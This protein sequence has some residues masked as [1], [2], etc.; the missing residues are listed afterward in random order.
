[1]NDTVVYS[2]DIDSSWK[3]GQNTDSRLSLETLLS[4][5]P[6]ISTLIST[7]SVGDLISLSRVSS[8]YRALTH[9]FEIPGHT[10]SR[11]T[12]NLNIGQHQTAR[13][14]QLKQAAAFIC[15]SPNHT[16]G[17][18]VHGCKLCSTTIC[19]TCIVR[20]SI[21]NTGENTF[22]KRTRYL[23]EPCWANGN[24]RQDYRFSADESTRELVLHGRPYNQRGI[25]C[26][27]SLKRDAWLCIPC[28][29]RQNLS[30]ASNESP[31]SERYHHPAHRNNTITT[32][33]IPSPI[34]CYGN[35]C[36]NI[37]RLESHGKRRICLWCSKGLAR[38]V[39]GDERHQWEAKNI[40]IRKAEAESR[41]ADIAEWR[42]NRF[43]SLTMSRR[44]MRGSEAYSRLAH[45]EGVGNADSVDDDHP[46][47][48]RHLDA[49]NYELYCLSSQHP[50]TPNDIWRSKHTSYFRY[51]IDFLLHIGAKGTLS[52]AD[53]FPLCLPLSERRQKRTLHNAADF[54]LPASVLEHLHH[55]TQ[56]Q[57]PHA[58]RKSPHQARLNKNLTLQLRYL[59]RPWDTPGRFYMRQLI[60]A[61][62][63]LCTANLIQP[64]ELNKLKRKLKDTAGL[65]VY[66]DILFEQLRDWEET[67]DEEG[68][69]KPNLPMSALNLAMGHI[70]ERGSSTTPS[71]WSDA[72]GD[73]TDGADQEITT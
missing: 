26:G 11:S 43:R 17:D 1:M 3:Y 18:N 70:A 38:Q 42:R 54:Q 64:S 71:L 27:C 10:S 63:R 50:P 4:I 32:D 25:Y 13:W 61:V 49:V 56:I 5:W 7:L 67:E 22:Q 15:A 6:I 21:R 68:S 72:D 23:C 8:T 16:R 51:S 31:S 65:K 62:P 24:L 57:L 36:S 60:L 12:L 47:L 14:R 35:D 73:S 58:R 33:K 52:N 19:E 46:I 55:T 39:G 28:K 29:R 37:I 59:P 20:D 45:S 44:Q 41:S 40:E 30:S 66:H 69:E 48:L 34:L 9:G 53:R 2:Q